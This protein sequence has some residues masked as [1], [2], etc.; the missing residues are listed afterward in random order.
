[1]QAAG[2]RPNAAYARSEL[3][4]NT[5]GACE[6][7]YIRQRVRR[8]LL[9]LEVPRHV[10]PNRHSSTRLTNVSFGPNVC[11]RVLKYITFEAVVWQRTSPSPLLSRSQSVTQNDR[12]RLSESAK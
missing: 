1:M 12:G 7:R 4:A 9:V 5:L 8:T 11:Y 6:H 10:D 2:S 3:P